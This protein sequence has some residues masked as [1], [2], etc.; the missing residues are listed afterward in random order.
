M[1]YE[2]MFGLVVFANDYLKLKTLP[3]FA[4]SADEFKLTYTECERLEPLS[5]SYIHIYIPRRVFSS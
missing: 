1:D 3:C 5:I 4:S 2:M